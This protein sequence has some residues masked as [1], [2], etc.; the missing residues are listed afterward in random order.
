ML[1]KRFGED[2][3]D[4]KLATM[5]FFYSERCVLR[6]LFTINWNRRTLTQKNQTA[7]GR[8]AAQIDADK[9][10]ENRLKM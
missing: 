9:E 2:C 8:Q 6:Y 3:E 4:G 5:Y 7:A 1:G 10:M